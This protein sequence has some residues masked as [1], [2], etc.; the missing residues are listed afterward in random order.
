MCKRIPVLRSC[1]CKP[2]SVSDFSSWKEKP[3]SCSSSSSFTPEVSN[4]LA[5]LPV[6]PVLGL[7]TEKGSLPRASLTNGGAV[8]TMS[9]SCLDCGDG[10][11][12]IG[13]ELDELLDSVSDPGES[14][15]VSG[16]LFSLT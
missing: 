14:V 10:D 7:P 2:K 8:F 15:M 5:S 4:D 12:I 6:P 1:L 11:I 9:E 13:D 3:L 16:P